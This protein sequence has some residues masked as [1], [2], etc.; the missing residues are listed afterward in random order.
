[1][2]T[3]NH[4]IAAAIAGTTL[5]TVGALATV[6]RAE[7]Q[8]TSTDPK[9]RAKYYYDEGRKQFDLGN[10]Q[11]AA[12]SF[13]KAYEEWP[14]GAFLYNVASAYRQLDDCKQAL[15]FYKRFLSVKKDAPDDKKKEVEGHIKN[16][17]D[18]VKK[19]EEIRN[20]PP[21]GTV[22]PDP[23]SGNDNG[24]P[25]GTP[26]GGPPGGSNPDVAR[27]GGD[28]VANPGGQP[29]GGDQDQGEPETVEAT[30]QPKVIAAHAAFGGA[31]IGAGDLKDPIPV[32]V[33][34]AVGAGYPIALGPKAVLDAGI[35][36]GFTP[37]PWSMGTMSGSATFTTVVANVGGTIEV[38][39]KIS[40]RGE[41]GGGLLLL[42]GLDVGNPFTIGAVAA[43]G[44]LVMPAV[45]AGVS[46]EYAITKNIAASVTPVAFSY[47]PAKAGLKPEISAFT[48]FEF[49]VGV[50]YRM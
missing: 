50:G 27:P 21:D 22:P 47:S 19:Q 2:K 40:V 14:D 5:G 34:V 20:R 46:A 8:P 6:G 32:Q 45:R 48:R 39:P 9:V 23:I 29:D 43:S 33:A 16:L 30:T 17:E 11:K 49:T 4:W 15:F 7:A 44:T 26:P 42:G 10:F 1:M 37:L 38:A 35:G 24:N 31:K 18:C 13:K 3:L 36:I 41:L 28:R 25:G 12:E